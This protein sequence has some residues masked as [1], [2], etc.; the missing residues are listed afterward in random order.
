MKSRTCKEC[1]AEKPLTEFRVDRHLKSGRTAK[2]RLCLNQYSKALYDRLYSKHRKYGS[3]AKAYFRKR[4]EDHK[5]FLN[6]L[7]G[8]PCADCK[9]KF[10]PVCMDFDHIEP[11]KRYALAQM[12]NHARDLVQEELDRCEVVCCNCHRVRTDSRIVRRGILLP[13]MRRKRESFLQWMQ[14]LKSAP[15]T[16]CGKTFPP[17]AM[18]FDHVRGEKVKGISAMWSW[19]RERILTELAKCDLVCANCHR[20]RTTSQSRLVA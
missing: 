8:Y 10:P 14:E 12:S 20:L 11:G 1:G 4:V 16:A 17:V 13:C 3:D 19:S 7:K 2:C 6:A 5:A 18:D 9:T 15:C